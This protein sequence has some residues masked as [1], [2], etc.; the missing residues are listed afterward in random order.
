MSMLL[1][2]KAMGLKVGNP[3]TKLVLLKLADN[4]NDTGYCWPSYQNI[5]DHSEIDRRTAMRHIK[6]LSDMGLVK[7]LW[8]K[9]DDGKNKSNAYQLTL[10][11]IDGD[12]LTLPDG[13]TRSL[14]GDRVTLPDGDHLSP[15]TSHSF[16][17]VIE[18]TTTT[19][20]RKRETFDFNFYSAYVNGEQEGPTAPDWV[21]GLIINH[22]SDNNLKTAA[23]DQQKEWN[24]FCVFNISQGSQPLPL[25]QA[26]AMFIRWL[27]NIKQPT[28]KITAPAPIKPVRQQ[29]PPA[30]QP[31]SL[32][33]PAEEILLNQGTIPVNLEK[34]LSAVG[35][36]KILIDYNII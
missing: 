32:V 16:E 27:S 28:K 25:Q 6:K 21:A 31:I 34:R 13:D 35:Y 22:C 20:A 12:N 3:T 14:G 26:K 2:V 24:K 33:T 4:A 8:R 18:P 5:A 1:M 11:S 10:D 29:E 15:R 36:A 23:F 30:Q 17:P 9:R 19:T 7:I